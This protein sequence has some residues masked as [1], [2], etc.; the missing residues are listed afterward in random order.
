LAAEA[1]ARLY[2]AFID[3]DPASA[4]QV[5]ESLR[6]SGVA[7]DALFDTVYA[8]AMSMLG[9]A[10][11]SGAIDEMAF[12]QAAVVAEQVSS[13]VMPA[14]A[15]RD[16][17]VTVVVGTVHTDVHSIARTIV[18]AT[19]KEAGY[20]INDLGADVRPADFVERVQ[21]TGARI[22]IAFAETMRTARSVA[23]IRD[24]LTAEGVDGVVLL[25]CGGPF[26]ADPSLAR[27]VGANGVI[28][29]AESALRLMSRVA[30][31]LASLG[32]DR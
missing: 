17:G 9:E 13:F 29:G 32:G 31:D 10:W 25:A 5:V 2:Q 4:I 11:A 27:A 15:K 30:H 6:A 23:S 20:R 14:A 3:Q 16:T 8:P 22:V 18:A 28:T 26:A 12:T 21:E 7:Q 24:T 19:L 1:A